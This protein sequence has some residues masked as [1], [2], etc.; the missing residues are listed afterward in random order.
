MIQFYVS[1]DLLSR[2]RYDAHAETDGGH[3]RAYSG[4][5]IGQTVGNKTGDERHECGAASD[6]VSLRVIRRVS[7]SDVIRLTK[8]VQKATRERLLLY[9]SSLNVDLGMMASVLSRP[10]QYSHT[11][12]AQA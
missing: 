3:D 4:Y 12:T 7:I 2:K 10:R 9:E 1:H 5:E 11:D 6:L 8:A